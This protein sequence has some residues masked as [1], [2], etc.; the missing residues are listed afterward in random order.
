MAGNYYDILGVSRTA[1]DA[2]IKKAYRGLARKYHP[3]V[4]PDDKSAESKFKEISEAYAVLSDA[5]KRKQYDSLGHDAFTSSGSGYDFSNMNS[6]NWK[7]FNFGGMSMD[8]LLGDFLGGGMGRK[9]QATSPQK[10]ADIQYSMAIPFADVIKGNEY[11]INVKHST[12]CPKCSGKGGDRQT[13]PTCRGTG[14]SSSNRSMFGMSACET[15]HGTG[16]I[17]KNVCSECSGRGNINVDDKI[18]VKIPAGVD[19]SSK[20]RIAG[21][22]DAGENGGSNGDLYILP[23]IPKHSVYE[24]DGADLSMNV[25]IGMFEAALGTKITVPTPYGAVNLNIP[26]G[27]Q[28][29]QRFRL[30][31]KGVPKLKG[32]VNGDL[33]VVLKVVVPAVNNEA[34]KA[35]LEKMMS[36]YPGPDRDSLLS[37]GM[38]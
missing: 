6:Q 19:N 36:K 21:K 31:G 38:L 7:D 10:G 32:G 26:A 35:E 28:Q 13:C 27:A 12:N 25:D 8:D 5:E 16:S 3:D 2:E 4:N 18:K 15:C 11:V 22:G 17:L 9:R 34:D 37:K 20:I 30:K 24:R 33:Y 23:K 1:T 14:F 29:G